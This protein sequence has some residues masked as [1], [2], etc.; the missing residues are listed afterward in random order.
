MEFFSTQPRFPQSNLEPLFEILASQFGQFMERKRAEEQ[1][2]DLEQEL[3][4]AQK[5][6]SLGILAGGIAHDFNNILT[7]TVG[8][9][10][11]ARQEITTQYLASET[12]N[13]GDLL[14]EAEKSV[15]RARGLTQQLLT[16]A[17]GGAPVRK[18][19]AVPALLEDVIGFVL[20][21]TKVKAH[22]VWPANLQLVHIDEGQI[23]QVIHNLIINAVQAMPEG[24]FIT[25][26]AQD[27]STAL[28]QK[29]SQLA[30]LLKKGMDY[31]KVSIKDEG[32]GIEPDLLAKIFDPYFTTKPTG[33]GLGLATSFSIL[34]RHEG[35]IT[36]ESQ[37]GQGTTFFLYLPA[38][39]DLPAV[40]GALALNKETILE[41]AK[42]LQIQL[43][44]RILVI[45]DETAIR[46][47]L[48]ILLTNRG[49]KVSIAEDGLEALK[50]Y[51]QAQYSAEVYD[52]VIVDLTLPGGIGGKEIMAQLLKL[53]ATVKV[54]VTSGYSTDPVVANYSEYGFAG[55]ISK[56]FLLSELCQQIDEV[57]K[58]T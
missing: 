6:E 42:Q 51:E 37:P 52:L 33:N 24:G 12:V 45:D 40:P 44:K 14:E 34:R 11:M 54:I 17:K 48:K 47:L 55:A 41:Q 31:V 30:S 35:F 7:A 38:S 25:V 27:V 19:Q 18:I 53:N 23:T 28:V 29:D 15:Y 26:G 9:L 16:F 4:K 8:Y 36:V 20:R 39:P 10:E 13:L 46:K 5:L 2:H 32:A 57:L 49:Y 21:G 1:A 22:F 50:L 43:T 3:L 56:P 58:Q